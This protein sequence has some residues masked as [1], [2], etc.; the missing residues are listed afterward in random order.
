MRIGNTWR[1]I[2]VVQGMKLGLRHTGQ[3][4]DKPK[5]GLKNTPRNAVNPTLTKTILRLISILFLGFFWLLLISFCFHCNKY[6]NIIIISMHNEHSCL[7]SVR[8]RHLQMWT[9][10]VCTY[11]PYTHMHA[12]MY[13]IHKLRQRL[14]CVIKQHLGSFITHKDLTALETYKHKPKQELQT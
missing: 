3:E 5:G 12:C 7:T 1:R 11:V 10:T 4:D 13:T 6:N 8:H 9:E 2:L 14:D